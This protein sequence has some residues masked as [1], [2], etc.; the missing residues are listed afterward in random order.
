M[1]KEIIVF[2]LMVVVNSRINDD[3]LYLSLEIMA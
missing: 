2:D 1:E 3:Q